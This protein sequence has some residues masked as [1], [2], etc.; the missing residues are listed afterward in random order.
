MINT[1]A[2]IMIAVAVPVLLICLF[3]YRRSINKMS[4]YDERQKL[5]QGRAFRDAYLTVS[6]LLVILLLVITIWKVDIPYYRGILF[7]ILIAGLT[8]WG[9]E[10]SLF[11]ADSRPFPDDP[12]NPKPPGGVLL[13][14]W[15][16]QTLTMIVSLSSTILN[17][18]LGNV[19]KVNLILVYSSIIIMMI[20]FTICYAIR[21]I[22]E[23]KE[24]RDG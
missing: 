22:R 14:I 16:L 15:I 20:A 4:P 9:C 7:F 17:D 5:I 18:N 19:D 6:A 21:L 11:Y 8:V 3:F 10:T 1:D 24:E 12:N 13:F 23:K 2:L